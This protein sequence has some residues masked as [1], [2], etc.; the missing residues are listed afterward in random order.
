MRTIKAKN[1]TL[2]GRQSVD[3]GQIGKIRQSLNHTVDNE[4]DTTSTNFWPNK[5]RVPSAVKPG[6]R[7]VV[8]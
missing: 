6:P 1:P 4:T 8:V 5:P 7:K 2:I 3:N